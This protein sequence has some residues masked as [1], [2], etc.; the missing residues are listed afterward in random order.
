MP[1]IVYFAAGGG[2][3]L[4][5]AGLIA[6]SV[7]ARAIFSRWWVAAASIVMAGLGIALVV[8][9]A[10]ALPWS[11]Y[12]IWFAA[13]VAWIERGR[14]RLRWTKA[15]IDVAELTVTIVAA[16]IA[17]SFQA[18]PALPRDAFSR[19]IIIGDS[20]SAGIGNE[21]S[22]LWPDVLRADHHVRV[23]N[24]ARA[25]AVISEGEHELQSHRITGA[26]ILLEIGGNDMLGHG[27]TDQFGAD[28]RD[29]AKQV[30]GPDRQV[31]MLELPLFPFNNGYGVQQRRA[32]SEYGIALIPRKYFAQVLAGR[33]ATIDGIHLS[34]SGHRRMAE[35]IWE[36][37]GA[38]LRNAP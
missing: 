19:L 13:T 8:I 32:A 25:G 16:S 14:F 4:P 15:L 35:M 38:S 34:A 10:E 31:V 20:I 26:L 7:A 17:I 5:G 6:A 23:V 24:L 28:L 9:S 21:H 18:R 30:C 27:N 11:V 33:G 22:S 1:W 12:V 36:M 37:V 2:T 29:L 3:F